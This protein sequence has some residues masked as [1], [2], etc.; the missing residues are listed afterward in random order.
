MEVVMVDS[1]SAGKAKMD[2]RLAAIR[3]RWEVV[4]RFVVLRLL[5]VFQ[6]R[7][8]NAVSD[9]KP[10]INE[11]K[12]RSPFDISSSV[13]SDCFLHDLLERCNVCCCILVN[14]ILKLPWQYP[15]QCGEGFYRVR[16]CSY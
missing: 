16:I 6:H 5:Q 2:D 1:S 9:P 4:N 13:F 3:R 14:V 15:H 10:D 11:L 12:V 8:Q 7:M